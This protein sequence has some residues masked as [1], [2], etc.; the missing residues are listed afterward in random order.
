[1]IKRIS[2][3]LAVLLVTLSMLAGC[4]NAKSTQSANQAADTYGKGMAANGVAVVNTGKASTATDGTVTQETAAASSTSA[5]Q[6]DYALGSTGSDSGNVSN[7][8]LDQRKVI[9]SANITTEVDDFDAAYGK[10][11]SLLLGI[12]FVQETNINTDRVYI[13]NVQKL[14]KSGTIVLRVDRNKFDK[15]L[16][17][18]KEVGTVLNW[19]IQGEDV[20]EKYYD[21][22]SRLKLL[23][24]EEERVLEYLKKITDPDK[25][26]S[27]ESRLTS[28]RQEIESL[29]GTLR[30]ISDLVDLSTITVTMNEKYPGSD[31][32]A[33][34]KNYWNRLGEKFMK[35]M[36]SV[37][38]F[39]GDFVIFIVSALPVL[40]LLG[41]IAWLAAAIYRKI[42]HSVRGKN[43][44]VKYESGKAGE[45]AE[46]DDEAIKQ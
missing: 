7:P 23:R 15:V 4:G 12:G 26:I 5:L 16:N 14:V 37:L 3:L 8:I 30:K 25:I 38:N 46:K 24:L 18:L 11:S 19:S 10:I 36:E 32:P 6:G 43:S 29:T 27:Y 17:G 40:L 13:N 33:A 39:C 20:T 2:M 28:I 44:G 21:T 31:K 34:E 22:E 45:N 35:N 41:L 1:M 42:R 9:R